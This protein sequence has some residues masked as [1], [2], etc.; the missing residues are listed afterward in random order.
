LDARELASVLSLSPPFRSKQVFAWLSRGA[1]SFDSMTDLPASERARLSSG[2][3]STFSSSVDARVDSED[4]TV[5]LGVRLA[6][7]ARVE[8]VL[9]TDIEGRSTACLSSQAGC[10]MGC[11]FCKTGTLGLARDL[12]AGEIVEQFFRLKAIRGEI[13]NVVYMGMGEP[14]L[15]LEQV[16]KSIALLCD[17]GGLGLSPRRITVST[18]G[19]VPGIAALAELG[20]KVRLAVS[21][22]SADP[23]IRS[24]LMPVND[25]YPLPELKSALVRYC[26][27]TGER[28]TLEVAVLGGVNSDDEEA[29][30]MAEFARG[31]NCQVNLIPWNPVEGMDFRSPSRAEVERLELALEAMGVRVTR[32]MR[33]GSD[34]SGACGQLGIVE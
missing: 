17:P 14:L 3:P 22:T 27:A 26:D 16:S 13:S 18:C 20:A 30:R 4:G 33:R 8:C 29:R 32:R 5:K 31:L 19:I 11:A 28:V 2:Y 24:R 7:S 1:E 21:L 25:A 6:D 12:D 23:A 15:N 10:S 9:L 34:V